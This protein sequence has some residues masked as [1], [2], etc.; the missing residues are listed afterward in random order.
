MKNLLN[1]LV[2]LIFISTTTVAQKPAA[3][4]PEF[5][6]FKLDN[7]SFT[8]KNLELGKLLFFVFFDTD[9]DHCQH[10]IKDI[11]ENY[12]AFNKT[13]V[14]L[15]T[16]DVKDKVDVFMNK[17]GQ[18][19]RGKKNITILRDVKLEFIRKFSPKKYPSMFL[20][21]ADKKLILYDDNEQNIPNF[22]QKIKVG[23]K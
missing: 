8:N 22:L 10:A 13:A 2:L 19:L 11:N 21:A 5:N 15:V 9:C 23:A 17:Y 18:N 4:L 3:V 14:Y 12:T 1:V 16:Q 6:F 7:T 20:Y